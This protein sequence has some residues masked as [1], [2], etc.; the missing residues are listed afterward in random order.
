MEIFLTLGFISYVASGVAYLF[1]LIV[2]F[3]GIRNRTNKAFLVLII[4][5][6]VWSA[7]LTLSQV[8]P[9]LSFKLITVTEFLRYFAWLHLLHHAAGYYIDRSTKFQITNPLSPVSVG[10][11]FLL[12]LLILGLNDE[13]VSF[14]ELRT[15]TIIQFGWM[16]GFSVLGLLLVEQVLRNTVEVDRNSINFLCIS[17]AAIF[18]FDFFVFSNALLLQ[19]IDY[20]F[21]SARGIINVLAIPTL[22]LAAVRNPRMAP[23]IHISRK[24]VL[25]STTLFAT[26]FYL[27]LMAVTGFYIKGSSAEWGTLAEVAFLLAALILLAV[28]FF[29]TDIRTRIKRYLSYSFQNKYDYR[30][31]WD[32]FSHTILTHDLGSSIFQRAIQAAGQIVD[33]QGGAVWIKDDQQF[34]Y[35]AAWKT[36]PVSTGPE[37]NDSALIQAIRAK[38]GILTVDELSTSLKNSDG[39]NHWIVSSTRSWLILPLMI[40]EELFGFI[41]LEQSRVAHALD[42]EDKDLLNTVTD[43]VA[44]ALFLN[45]ADAQLQVAQRFKDLDQMTAFLVHDLKTVFSQL[46]LLVENADTHKRNPEFIDDMIDTVE[47]T[48]QKMQRLLEQLRD[49]EKEITLMKFPLIPVIEEIVDSY[50]HLPAEVMMIS[51]LDK[52]PAIRADRQQLISAI[53]HIVQNGVESVDNQGQV[54]IIVSHFD[55]NTIELLIEDNGIGMTPEF[56]NNSLFKPFESTKGVSGM[57]VGVYQSREYVRSITGDIEVTSEQGIGTRFKILL[58]VEYE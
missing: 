22:L 9:S 46:S 23:D 13:L 51:D 11:L 29:S 36:D 35:K 7:T 18:V 2:Y 1:L 21:W 40:N 34:V 39:D 50:Q 38:K 53:R 54:K 42:I 49:P 12:S 20:D 8:G 31:E 27:L 33:S 24:F 28:L 5:T 16:L 10:V 43:H 45:E 30:E 56:I 47:H 3:I 44:L 57:G 58:P 6:L 15:P 37:R 32:R 19:R 41:L 26:G 4:A 55:G 14:F 48:T 52:I 17:A 25:H